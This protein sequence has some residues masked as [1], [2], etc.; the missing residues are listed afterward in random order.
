M[1]WSDLNTLYSC[2]DCSKSRLLLSCF[3]LVLIIA[4][5]LPK[6]GLQ[7]ITAWHCVQEI[8]LKHC[9]FDPISFTQ[10]HW[11]SI[12]FANL[13]LCCVQ[14]AANCVLKHSFQMRNSRQ[15]YLDCPASL[16]YTVYNICISARW[17][18]F[19]NS[20]CQ[21]EADWIVAQVIASVFVSHFEYCRK[22]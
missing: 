4:L 13:L 15:A 22:R 2:Q 11:Y 6:F 5:L 19:E 8:V 20:R 18:S 9:I 10:Y 3:V 16:A 17:L 7:I 21:Q 14:T 12:I 1:S